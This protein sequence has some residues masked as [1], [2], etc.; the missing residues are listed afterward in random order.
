MRKRFLAVL[1]VIATQCKHDQLPCTSCLARDGAALPGECPILHSIATTL[2][3]TS[4]RM[5][6]QVFEQSP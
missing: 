4:L 5:H 3:Q 6:I 1:P 2:L